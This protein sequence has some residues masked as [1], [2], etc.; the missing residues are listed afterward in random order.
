MEKYKLNT[1]YNNIIDEQLGT[2]KRDNV[3]YKANKF[4]DEWGVVILDVASV[5]ALFIPVVGWGISAG[6]QMGSS[7]LSYSKGDKYTAGLN[8]IF[9]LIPGGKLVSKIPA[10]KNIKHANLKKIIEKS[11]KGG[12]LSKEEAILV[13][14]IGKNANWLKNTAKIGAKKVE[15]IKKFSKLKIPHFLYQYLKWT[16]KNKIK[17][18]ILKMG[19]TVGGVWY[20]FDLIAKRY[21]IIDSTEKD[22]EEMADLNFDNLNDVKL[23][24]FDDLLGDIFDEVL[25]SDNNE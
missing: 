20:S 3:V 8:A 11:N 24:E 16:K 7:Y 21:N 17:T 6:L 14:E 15:E 4:W 22:R 23:E 25:N 9:A 10:L 5:G 12:K 13:K 1:I 2:I 18:N 19:I